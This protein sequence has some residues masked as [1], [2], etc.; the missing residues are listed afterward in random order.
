M[1]H[2]EQKR[3]NKKLGSRRYFWFLATVFLLVGTGCE[4]VDP[5]PELK[6]KIYLDL[7]QTLAQA[8]EDKKNAETFKQMARDELKTLETGDPEIATLNKDIR[9]ENRKIKAYNQEIRYLEIR[10][11][12]RRLESRLAYAES[13]KSEKE[14]PDTRE[15]AAY[16]AHKNLRNASPNWNERV[17]RL[18]ERIDKYT[19]KMNGE[20]EPERK[21]DPE[22]TEE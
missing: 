8:Q 1:F 16:L 10:L 21:G 14:Y 5:F 22:K 18:K 4:S 15:Y 11:E 2:V 6:D 20:P 17:P 13:L 12:R 19:R 7:Q 3:F 9:K